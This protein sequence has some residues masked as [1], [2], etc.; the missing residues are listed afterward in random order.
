VSLDDSSYLASHVS[1]SFDGT[2]L[3]RALFSLLNTL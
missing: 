2:S 1:A 3:F